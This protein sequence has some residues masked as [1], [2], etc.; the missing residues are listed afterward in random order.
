MTLVGGIGS[1][2]FAVVVLVAL[3]AIA[4]I[5]ARRL[6]IDPRLVL[7]FLLSGVAWRLC[8]AVVA[9]EDLMMTAF[10]G[11]AVLG[12]GL[13]IAMVMVPIW[14]AIWRHRR[15]PLFP[16]DAMLLGAFGFVFGPLGLAWTLL[17]GSG[18]AV[19]HRI[20]LQR[21]RSRPVLAGY[22]PLGPGMAAGAA[23]VFVGLNAG[24]ALAAGEGVTSTVLPDISAPASITATELAPVQASLP[25]ELAA[26]EIVLDQRQPLP[27]SALASRVGVLAGVAVAIEERPSR[28]VGGGVVLSEVPAMR[29]VFKGSFI[30]LLDRLALRS[31]Y[32]WEWRDVAG[33]VFYRYWDREQ[34]APQ[35]AQ[36][37]QG[38]TWVVDARAHATLRA[39][40]ESWADQ[41]GWS[42]VWKP[43]RHFSVAADATFSG[44]FL[45]AVDL[46][47]GGGATR[48]TLVAYAYK[49]NRHLVIEDAEAVWP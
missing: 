5:D 39:V 33:L 44:G 24:I 47:L 29:L 25:A 31:G 6:I 15:W 43:A 1:W 38:T 2:V 12:L 30:D 27:F 17:F 3:A 48:R 28:V 13:G 4:V 11:P 34:G 32:E 21:R 40:L 49:P 22:T 7:A 42:L 10:W 23:M 8:R 37:A 41:A 35:R 14:I 18:L 46:L 20:C 9:G 19:L 16:G 36:G 26:R 45:E